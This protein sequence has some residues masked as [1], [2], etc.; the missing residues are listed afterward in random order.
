VVARHGVDLGVTAPALVPTSDFDNRHARDR[1]LPDR[2]ITAGRIK[3]L[4]SYMIRGLC[5]AGAGRSTGPPTGQEQRR[6]GEWTPPDQAYWCRYDDR[7]PT[8]LARY[9]TST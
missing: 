6:P 1:G 2:Q 8:I 7:F 3:D 9:R 4:P 5:P